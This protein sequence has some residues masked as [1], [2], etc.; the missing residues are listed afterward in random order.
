MS[1]TIAFPTLAPG[2][3]SLPL[4]QRSPSTQ[5]SGN[6]PASRCLPR[7]RLA[8]PHIRTSTPPARLGHPGP[9]WKLLPAPRLVALLPLARRVPEPQ[10]R[11]HGRHRAAPGDLPPPQGPH[12]AMDPLAPRRPPRLAGCNAELLADLVCLAVR[13]PFALLGRAARESSRSWASHSS[14]PRSRGPA[15]VH[16]RLGHHRASPPT[17][18]AGSHGPA[19]PPSRQASDGAQNSAASP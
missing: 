2:T 15:A 7:S 10:R 11:P 17:R 4:S 14:G 5:P 3:K 1:P 9:R 8:T 19:A 13:A 12:P 16:H 6:A 18:R